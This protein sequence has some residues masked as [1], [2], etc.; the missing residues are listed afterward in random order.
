MKVIQY[1]YSYEYKEGTMNFIHRALLSMTR[2]LDKSLLLF[3]IVFILSNV[4]AG[5]IAIS[6]ASKNVEVSMKQQLGANATIE[7]DY[8][9]MQDWTE[10]DWA[11]LK[12][13][14]PEMVETIGALDQV[15]Y[16]DYNIE[17]WLLGKDLKTYDPNIT[18]IYEQNY[19]G[20]KGVHFAEVLDIT[21]GKA[22]LVDGRVFT[23]SEVDAGSNLALISDKFAEINNLH[24]GDL[25]VLTSVYYN[26]VGET[27]ENDVFLEIIGIFSPRMEIENENKRTSNQWIDY[28]A[29]NRIYTSNAVVQTQIEWTNNMYY[30]EYPDVPINNMM[31][32]MPIFVLKEP[33]LVDSFKVDAVLNLP[34]YYMVRA[35]ADAYDSVAGPIN[36]IGS[37]SNM[38]LWSA[39]FATILILSLVVILFLRDRKHEFGIYLS[40]GEAKW[41]IL[42][43][44]VTEV[45]VVAF[46][47][48]SLSV[49][50]GS[51]IADMTSQAMIDMGV[52]VSTTDPNGPIAYDFYPGYMGGITQDDVIN[53]YAIDFNL[54]YVLILYGVGLGTVLVSTIAPMLYLL[55]L[56]PKKILM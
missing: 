46:L 36:F 37:L 24:L 10:D 33:E 40:L 7:L 26:S 30:E 9:K 42:A 23:Q 13:I 49:F 8:N 28:S 25:M 38:I 4:M 29:Y 47:A 55:R 2:R 53:A 51:M 1:K 16:F 35:D 11:N 50:S 48:I 44:M 41:K 52:G 39:I 34:D 27:I 19:F 17:S 56:K 5:S 32:I 45:M 18:E 20:L 31:Y 14:S 22:D 54:E 15:K 43:Q 21:T 12:W 3:L 6:Q